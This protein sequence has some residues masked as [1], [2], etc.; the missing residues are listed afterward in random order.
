MLLP[1]A[2]GFSAQKQVDC[3]MRKAS[4]TPIGKVSDAQRLPDLDQSGGPPLLLPLHLALG[5]Q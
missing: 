4:D 1:V 5:L 3:P 2:P